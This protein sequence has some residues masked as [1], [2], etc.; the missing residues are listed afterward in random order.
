V[1]LALRSP[2]F[3]STAVRAASWFPTA[4]SCVAHCCTGNAAE[5]FLGRTAGLR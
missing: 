5:L 1:A 3:V 2:L 4:A